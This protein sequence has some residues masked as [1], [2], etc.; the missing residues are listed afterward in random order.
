[1]KPLILS[2]KKSVYKPIEVEIDGKVYRAKTINREILDEMGKLEEGI[3]TGDAGK[4]YD[5]VELIFGN[6]Q[7]FNKLELRQI[8]DIVAHV[9][10]CLFSPE[11]VEPKGEEKNASRPG[12]KE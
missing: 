11:K 8:N 7:I 3:R 10:K 6:G 12:S 5:Q 2:T 9:T 4:A 1:M